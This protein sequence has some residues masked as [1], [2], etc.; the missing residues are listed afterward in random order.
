MVSP[1]RRRHPYPPPARAAALPAAS[2]R[3][4]RIA[5]REGRRAPRGAAGRDDAAT[6][7]GGRL[8]DGVE[9][10]WVSNRP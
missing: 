6:A 1:I 9:R 4:R 7:S 8:G 2:G 10:A 3:R 5:D